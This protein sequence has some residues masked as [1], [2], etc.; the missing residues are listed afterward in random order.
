MTIKIINYKTLQGEKLKKNVLKAVRNS[1][2]NIS[3]EFINDETFDNKKTFL[4]INEV[5]VSDK[6]IPSTRKIIKIINKSK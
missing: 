1:N 4:V 6:R 2:K 5:V 3:I